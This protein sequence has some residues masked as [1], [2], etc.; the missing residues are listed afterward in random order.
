MK[1]NE[2]IFSARLTLSQVRCQRPP[3]P[4]SPL[5]WYELSHPVQ[6]TLLARPLFEFSAL[7]MQAGEL[8][9][10][11]MKPAPNRTIFQD[12]LHA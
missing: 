5:P 11:N 3:L 7:A 10:D 2:L 6:L 4:A 9:G 12:R 1:F 8:L